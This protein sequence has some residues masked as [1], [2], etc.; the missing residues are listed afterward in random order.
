[1]PAPGWLKITFRIVNVASIV[2][3][4]LALILVLHKSPAPNVP[5]DPNAATRVEQKFAAADQAKA[6][7]QPAQVQMD[8]TELNS[9]LNQNLQLAG[10][11]QASAPSSALPSDSQ[12]GNAASP[13]ATSSSPNDSAAAAAALNAGGDQPSIEQVQSS[14]KDVKIDMDGDL[15]KAYVI[16]DFHGKDLSLELDGHLGAQDGYLKFIPVAG[17][18]DLCR[19]LNPRSMRP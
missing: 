9:Y 4:G 13:S 7:G 2:A 15:I 12:M 18:L 16:F 6:S 10:Q 11:P 19:C 1:M 14:V 5:N 8:S 3:L 17:K